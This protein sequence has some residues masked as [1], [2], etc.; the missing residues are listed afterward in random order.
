MCCL[1]ARS[2]CK[3][4]IVDAVAKSFIVDAVEIESTTS[5]IHDTV[6]SVC[7]ASALPLSYAPIFGKSLHADR[8]GQYFVNPP[9]QWGPMKTGANGALA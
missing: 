4:F 2:A 8:V 6:C 5:R 7:K 3:R 9:M 1:Q